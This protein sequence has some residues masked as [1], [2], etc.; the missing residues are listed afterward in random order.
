VTGGFRRLDEHTIHQGHIWRVAVATFEAPDGSRFE[1]DVVRSPGA[2]GVVPLD[3]DPEGNPVVVL[4]RQY[5]P[6][7]DRSMV[8]IPAGMRDVEGEPPEETARRE[9][10]EEAGLAARTLEP[11]VTFHNSAGMTDA[12]TIVFVATDL[13]EVPHDR[14]G[15]EEEHLDVLRVG[16]RD[17]LDDI[18]SGAI[19]DAKTVVALLALDRRLRVLDSAGVGLDEPPPGPAG[20]APAS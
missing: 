12:E 7:L 14:H 8:E 9:L 6:V 16:L 19:T 15:P 17:A 18:G 4:V 10:A 2:V 1:R 5:R 11:L 3:F 20:T 13:T